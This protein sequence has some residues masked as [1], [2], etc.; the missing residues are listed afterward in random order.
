MDTP[1]QYKRLSDEATSLNP[2]YI[3]E[4]IAWYED[5]MY[6]KM[7]DCEEIQ[8]HRVNDGDYYHWS[9]DNKVH[10]AYTEGYNDYVVKHPEQWDYLNGRKIIWLPRQDQLQE[11]V[12]I[13]DISIKS[14]CHRL[15]QAFERFC[16]YTLCYSMGEVTEESSAT[17]KLTS[18]EQLWLAFVMKELYNKV[19]EDNDW[20][21]DGYKDTS[22][23]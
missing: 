18:M 2:D 15:L 17:R 13:S 5:P 3:I 22:T 14:K 9:V 7:C 20:R 19:W 12:E 6:I 16:L 10:I 21:S 23:Q 8:A 1:E 11:M 4:R